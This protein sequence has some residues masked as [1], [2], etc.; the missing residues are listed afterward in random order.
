MH[1][2]LLGGSPITAPATMLDCVRAPLTT[3]SPVQGEG[4]CEPTPL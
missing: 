2:G 3:Q 4:E 1:P